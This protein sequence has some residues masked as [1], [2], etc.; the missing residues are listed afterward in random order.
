M[1]TLKQQ[2]GTAKEE[3]LLARSSESKH[4][5]ILASHK[6]GMLKKRLS[7]VSAA[8]QAMGATPEQMRK[9]A[10]NLRDKV[11]NEVDIEG[12]ADKAANEYRK[13]EESSERAAEAS[14]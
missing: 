14:M 2:I 9:Q 12:R 10:D 5:I 13:S 7:K 11:A 3:L 4:A 8:L 1:M 6:F